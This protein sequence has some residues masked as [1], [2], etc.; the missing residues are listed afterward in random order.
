MS[1]PPD[2]A[3]LQ[4]LIDE[5]GYK[6]PRPLPGG[7]FACV[8]RMMFTHALL[9]GRIGDRV[10]Y[11]DRWCYRSEA[12]AYKALQAWDGTG[13]PTGWVR[14]PD[15]GRRVSESPDERDQNGERVGEVGVTYVRG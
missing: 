4:W 8:A 14:H 11:A 2:L 7:R 9:V 13:E 5:C 10:G 15:S 6:H 1:I 3:F 12:A